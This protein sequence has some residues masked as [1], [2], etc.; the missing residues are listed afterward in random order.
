MWDIP[1]I[2]KKSINGKGNTIKGSNYELNSVQVK[3]FGS[4][5]IITIGENTILTN[6][7]FE[8]KGSNNLISIGS[9]CKLKGHILQKD[10]GSKIIIGNNTTIGHSAYFLAQENCN[11]EIGKD[12]MFSY[13]VT[14]RTTDA[15]SIIDLATGERLNKAKDVTIGNHV[16]IG[17]DVMLS[18]GASIPNDCIVGTRAL[19]T[20]NF[21]EP[22]CVIAGVPAKVLKTGVNWSRERI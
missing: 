14:V 3:I 22:N 21:S 13:R 2:I 7:K 20:K 1:G 17:A 10:I 19:V 15:H 12:C 8:I 6:L 4:N 5:N 18:K 11:I 9:D 16:W